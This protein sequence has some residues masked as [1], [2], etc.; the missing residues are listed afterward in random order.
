MNRMEAMS[1]AQMKSILEAAKTAG[2]R[3]WAFITM[4]LS[5]TYRVSEICKLTVAD[6]DL[7]DKTVSIRRQKGSL[8]TV[9]ALTPAELEILPRLIEGKK[10]SD[11]LFPFGRFTAYRFF[12]RAA[13]AAGLPKNC[14]GPHSTKHSILQAAV[15]AGATL[16]QV[17]QIGGHREIESSRRYWNCSQAKADSFRLNLLAVS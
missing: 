7:K 13:E 9:E 6:F 2:F 12:R 10:K 14:R 4:A 16:P 3:E 5:H 8:H 11:R 17:L 1:G 15:D